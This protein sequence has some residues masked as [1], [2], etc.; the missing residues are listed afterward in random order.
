MNDEFDKQLQGVLRPVEPDAGFADRVLARL[1]RDGATKVHALQPRKA[2]GRE[3]LHTRVPWI[4]AAMAATLIAGVV[5]THLW[6]ERVE[7]TEGLAA[8]QQLMEALRVTSE[9]LD[10]AY[11]S[12]NTPTDDNAAEQSGA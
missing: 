10:L 6:Q 8:R 7:R 3:R 4:P 11:Q 9:K 5:G 1:D 2:A 12:V